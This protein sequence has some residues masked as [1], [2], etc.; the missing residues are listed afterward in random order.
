MME[1]KTHHIMFYKYFTDM[2]AL[3]VVFKC[4]GFRVLPFPVDIIM[5]RFKYT[6]NHNGITERHAVSNQVPLGFQQ[7][8]PTQNK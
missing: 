6:I 4:S 5:I 7:F 3:Q 8:I 2:F 1:S